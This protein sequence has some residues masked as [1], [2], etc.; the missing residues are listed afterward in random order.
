MDPIGDFPIQRPPT[1]PVE[2]GSRVGLFAGIASMLVVLAG[3][4]LFYFWSGA[5]SPG[6]AGATPSERSPT[7][8]GRQALG[9]AVEP[10]PLPALDESDPLVR[11]LLGALSAHPQVAAWL[12]TDD[13]V[14]QFVR[15]LDNVASGISP[16]RHLKVLAPD[17]PFEVETRGDHVQVTETTYARYDALAEAAASADTVALAT[18]YARLKPRLQ[19]AYVELGHP[20]GDID[21]AVEQAI[22]RLLDTPSPKGPLAVRNGIISFK[23]DLEQ[24]ESL[25]AAQKQLLRMGPRNAQMVKQQL[26]ALARELGIPSDRL[27]AA[28]R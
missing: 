17:A 26:W 2:R 16:A 4:A 27:P 22:V 18:L 5:R 23:Y 10:G 7:T 3:L 15:A 13:L 9:P 21:A 6:T 20:A 14:R 1:P 25:S 28:D 8:A 11:Q 12:A 19:E 24:F